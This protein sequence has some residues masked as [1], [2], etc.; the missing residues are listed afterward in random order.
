MKKS[1]VTEIKNDPPKI[2][3]SFSVQPKGQPLQSWVDES[4]ELPV[5]IKDKYNSLVGNGLAKVTTSIQFNVKNFGQGVSGFCS[6]TLT[7]NQDANTIDEAMNMATQV[8][9]DYAEQATNL[10]NQNM[11][12]FL[13]E[14]KN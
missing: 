8:A 3:V 14:G 10:A 12:K 7:C 5:E 9:N 6:V 2:E 11:A 4:Q 1:T 13:T